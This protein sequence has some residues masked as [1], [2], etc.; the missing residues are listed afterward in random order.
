MYKKILV[1]AALGLALAGCKSL[2]IG[3][4]GVIPPIVIGP[5]GGQVTAP[6]SEITKKVTEAI[7]KVQA[8]TR[9]YCK[10]IPTASTVANV[11]SIFGVKSI[12]D[13]TNAAKEICN[14]VGGPGTVQARRA[15][16]APRLCRGASCVPIRGTRTS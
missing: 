8:E 7:E 16:S 10:F 2:T 1:V 3:G 9:K 4:G 5:G 6:P 15:G 11:L 12:G 13:L 14:A